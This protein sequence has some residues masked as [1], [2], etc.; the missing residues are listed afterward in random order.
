MWFPG[1]R[2]EKT[3]G[4]GNMRGEAEG[5]ERVTRAPGGVLGDKECVLEKA[6]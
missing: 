6:V 1:M 3:I 2:N 5:T 4:E